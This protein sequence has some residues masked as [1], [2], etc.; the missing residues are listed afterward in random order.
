MSDETLLVSSVGTTHKQTTYVYN[1]YRHET[2]F[3]PVALAEFLEIDRVLLARTREAATHDDALEQEFGE[4]VPCGFETISQVQ[5]R[6]DI[7]SMMGQ[8]I[9]AIRKRGPQRVVLDVTHGFRSLPMV[10]FAAVMHLDAL[11]DIELDG[12]YYSQFQDDGEETPI[13]DLTYLHT[14]MEWYHAINT[15]KR[16]GELRPVHKLLEERKESLFR[17]SEDERPTELADLV[18]SLG[19]VSQNLDAG[20]PLKTG[21][22]ARDT[23]DAMEA[24][25]NSQFI[26]PEERFL[27]PLSGLLNR[28][29][30]DSDVSNWYDIP[31]NMNEIHRQREL[32]EFYT[33]NGRHRI[34]LECARE[35]FIN[36]FILEQGTD[37]ADWLEMDVR[38]DVTKQLGEG[39]NE[40]TEALWGQLRE[41][42]NWYAH[43]GFKTDNISSEDKITSTL[44]VLCEKLDDSEYWQNIV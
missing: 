34:A 25:D 23:L 39:D 26:G 17:E 7:D 44:S 20:I 6:M 14:L 31:L 41:P 4:I 22:A 9:E 18:S 11:D 12:I 37:V 28:V 16:T 1:K 29:S 40:K 33:E 15:F 10:F 38:A 2:R 35:L 42:R 30:I 3:S 36:R 21:T 5:C 8:L 13:I 27:A 24:I 43:S 32:V 19:C